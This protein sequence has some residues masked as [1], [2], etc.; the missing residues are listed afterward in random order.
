MDAGGLGSPG[1]LIVAS[2]CLLLFLA[3]ECRS[4]ASRTVPSSHA[5]EEMPA[6][7]RLRRLGPGVR[8]SPLA[9]WQWQCGSARWQA[10]R[11]RRLTVRSF[12][13]F[14]DNGGGRPALVGI[15]LTIMM[16][17][18]LK[19]PATLAA[20]RASGR[21]RNHRTTAPF[22]FKR[23]GRTIRLPGAPLGHPQAGR[24]RPRPPPASCLV[25][26]ECRH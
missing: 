14:I 22:Q 8:T 4:N 12:G 21:A 19:Q 1:S 13:H 2:F 18:P 9:L 20:R 17:P 11:W 16:T 5:S 24:H 6:I 7:M 25:E 15:L 3:A 23:G 10:A 26:P